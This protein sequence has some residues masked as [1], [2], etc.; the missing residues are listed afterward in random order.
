[1]RCF[2]TVGTTKFDELVEAATSDPFLN[3]LYGKGYR[4]LLIQAGTS[5]VHESVKDNSKVGVK[6]Y[7]YK[8]NIRG[9]I[10]SAHLVISHAGAGSCLEIMHAKKP[11]IVVIND[12]L[13]GNHQTELAYKLASLGHVKHTVPSGLVT[14]LEELDTEELLPYVPGDPSLLSKHIHD[15]MG[16]TYTT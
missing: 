8:P 6:W 2:I 12:T 7:R 3:V 11:C 9:D 13:M 1:M 4:H 14:A 15:L 5:F 16:L 10:E